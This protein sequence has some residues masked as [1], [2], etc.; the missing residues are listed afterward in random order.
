VFRSAQ[1]ASRPRPAS[2]KGNLVVEYES[3]AIGEHSVSIPYAVNTRPLKRGTTISIYK[4]KQT[5][6]KTG[7]MQK[8]PKK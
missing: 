7:P 2:E 6:D 3:V 4:K 5:T 1:C 8:V